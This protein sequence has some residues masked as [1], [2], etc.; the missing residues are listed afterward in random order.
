MTKFIDT[1]SHL[2]SRKFDHD[3]AAVIARAQEVLH[4]VFLPNIDLESVDAMHA[5]TD[6]APGFFFP[7][8]GLHPCDVKED[9]EAQL[10]RMEALLDKGEYQYV[11]IGETG[12]DLYWDKTTLDIQVEALKIQVEW[13]KKRK[14]PVIL[15]SRNATDET[16]DVIEAHHDENLTGI[17]HCFGGTVEQARRVSALG[18]FAMGIGGVVTFKNG[19][20]AEL[21]ADVDI[22]DL[23]LE[24]DS[25]YLSPVPFRGKRNESSYTKYVAEKLVDVYDL[26]LSEIARITNENAQNI[27]PAA[28]ISDFS[29]RSDS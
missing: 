8:M 23:V 5:L 13:A 17:F 2:Y 10:A 16:L 21:L 29:V 25:P 20:L 24:T 22:H 27:F 1:H 18:N 14:L 4:A 19:G 6:K 12:I 7:M 11:G 15:H 3:Q 28:A 9:F 26:P